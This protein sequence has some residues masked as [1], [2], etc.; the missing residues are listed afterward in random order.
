MWQRPFGAVPVG[1][2]LAEFRVW[3]PAAGAVAVRL[4]GRDEELTGAGDGAAS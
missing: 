4:R 3:A 2:G 1:E